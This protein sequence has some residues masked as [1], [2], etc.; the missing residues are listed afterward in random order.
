MSGEEEQVELSSESD[1]E[2]IDLDIISDIRVDPNDLEQLDQ[3][4]STT[5]NKLCTCFAI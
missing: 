4:I 1:P 2:D 5:K 3:L